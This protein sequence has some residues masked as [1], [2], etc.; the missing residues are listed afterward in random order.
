MG[1]G[2]TLPPKLIHSFDWKVYCL[3][4]RINWD[5]MQPI[6]DYELHKTNKYA[7]SFVMVQMSQFKTK[8]TNNTKKIR[9]TFWYAFC[10]DVISK[11]FITQLAEFLSQ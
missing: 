10:M 4:E 1:K 8:Q 9:T 3:I 2:A 6:I 7:R 11:T 5:S